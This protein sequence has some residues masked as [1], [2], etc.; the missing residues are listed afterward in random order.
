MGNVKKIIDLLLQMQE[1][2]QHPEIHDYTKQGEG[3]VGLLRVIGTGGD[4]V[5]LKVEKGRIV[6]ARGDEPPLHIIKMSVDT[7]ISILSG[8]EDL[9][10]AITRGHV[11]LEDATTE[12]I[13]LVEMEK[14]SRAFERLKKIIESYLWRSGIMGKI[15]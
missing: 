2:I 8:E 9:R 4:S 11:V 12:S 3:R 5:L 7:F 1:R 15:S 14:W 6:Y 13:D 10:E